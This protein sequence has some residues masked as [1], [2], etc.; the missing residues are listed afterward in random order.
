M[1]EDTFEDLKKIASPSHL[2]DLILSLE[3]DNYE[4]FTL[5]ITAAETLIKRNHD[6]LGLLLNDLSQRLLRLD[7]RFNVEGFA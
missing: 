5:G 6:N 7:N 4:R 1:E 3:S 2:Y